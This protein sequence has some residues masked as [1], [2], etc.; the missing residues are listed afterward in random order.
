MSELRRNATVRRVTG[1]ALEVRIHWLSYTTAA[2]L[3]FAAFPGMTHAQNCSSPCQTF[4]SGSGLSIPANGSGGGNS[5]AWAQITVP[6]NAFG[7][8]TTINH[9]TVTL[10][11][12]TDD[13]GTPGGLD[14]EFLLQGPG[15]Q[16]FEFA[17]DVSTDAGFSNITWTFDDSAGSNPPSSFAGSVT[18]GTYKPW[19]NLDGGSLD[20]YCENFPASP[21]FSPSSG[22]PSNYSSTVAGSHNS[23]CAQQSGKESLGAAFNGTAASGTWT[24]WEFTHEASDSAATVANVAISITPAVAAGTTTTVSSNA[25][26]NEVFVGNSITFT[27]TV[28][29][30]STD[31][32]EGTVTFDD[33]NNQISGCVSVAVS[34][35]TAN[36]NTSFS[37]EGNHT[38]TATYN[39]DSNYNTSSGTVTVFVDN[40]TTANGS[41]FCN[42][43][44]ITLDEVGN[45]QPA[46]PYPQHVFVSSLTG[47]V[48]GVSLTLQNVD[49][50]LGSFE[51]LLVGPDGSAFVPLSKA[52]ST[53]SKFTGNLILSD[54]AGSLVPQNSTPAAGTYLPTDYNSDI[55]FPAPAPSGSYKTP[56]TVGSDTFATA[57]TGEPA[58]NPSEDK[59][60]LYVY[61]EQFQ[62]DTETIGGYCLTFT[63]NNL[64]STT[65]TV[66]SSPSMQ[67]T[68]GTSVTFTA[69]VMSGS[70]PVNGQGTVKFEENGTVL[71]G[72][73]TV[74]SSGQ[75]TF[76]SSTLAEGI[77]TIEAIYSG[78]PGAFNG[79]SGTVTIEIDT[80]TTNSS[81]GVYCNPGGLNIASGV[82]DSGETAT[83]YPSRI[84][85]TGE[86]GT[87]NT[88][89][90]S[91][92]G[93]TLNDPQETLFM[94]EGP[95]G[96]NVVFWDDA[97]GDTAISSPIN[98][99]FSDS[100]SGQLGVNTTPT[101]DSSYQP[102]ANTT[103][104]SVPFPTTAIPDQPPT[105]AYAAPLG[106]TTFTTA[107]QNINPN[108]YWSLFWFNRPGS[109]PSTVGSWCLNVVNNPPVVTL[110]K[111]HNG[112][113][114]QG[115][116]A[117][118]Y[119]ITVANPSGPGS[120]SG[121]MTLTDTLPTGMSAVSMSQT[122]GGTG[123]DWTCSAGTVSCTRTSAMAPGESDTITLTVSV[124]YNASTTTNGA[125]NNVSLSGGGISGSPVT[126]QDTQTVQVGPGYVLNLSVNP[127]G[128]GTITANPS[129]SAGLAAGHYVPGTVVT[130]TAN[131]TQTASTGYAF[132]SWS[133]SADLSGTS[134]NPTTIT[135]NSATESVTANFTVAYTSVSG[136]SVSSNSFSYNKIKKQGTATYTVSNNSGATISG[137]IQLVLSGMPAGVTGANNT[138]TFN[139]NPYWTATGG[140]LAPGASVQV[141]VTLA[142]PS[143]TNFTTTPT[144]YSGNLQ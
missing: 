56:A 93:L 81:A 61:S 42:N 131:P 114:T 1:G 121:T 23:N 82:N 19:V 47:S 125:V 78:A 13:G 64:P 62:G 54:S 53:N 41:T 106:S 68:T 10:K 139:G 95:S 120:T 15:G 105:P 92:N 132:S 141:S 38:I 65:T 104:P 79:S 8:G 32:S 50:Y 112:T 80:P 40:Q 60:S 51:L 22:V 77:H 73:T 140:S 5:V 28:K 123:S 58:D 110:A 137:P 118:T 39:G 29:S 144:V 37:T 14:R 44:T 111:V 52:G 11:N 136:A 109:F 21:S 115:D 102:T 103:E 26:N 43:G 76:T 17:A 86:A 18:N 84:N 48:T 16:T 97:G 99:T 12:W 98:L 71:S 70:N 89:S 7:A 35:G 24:V 135:M 100:A 63:T 124:S 138:G 88:V 20:Q 116:S 31:V 30:G 94:L 59:W 134:Q 69:T 72:P 91:L 142:Y 113:F 119:T 57:F 85:V 67:T 45:A 122:G 33:G 34:G 9:I 27:A 4:T 96:T 25:P 101:N 6:S 2:I 130:L 36:C 107:F 87:I 46:S 55:S 129:N 126:A 108:N 90:V 83:P 74:N 3:V 127:S 143:G 133:G 128:A 66:Q 49:A 75:A 117:D